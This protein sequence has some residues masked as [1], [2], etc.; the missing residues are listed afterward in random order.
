MGIEHC[1]SQKIKEPI[2][3]FI[4]AWINFIV[5]IQCKEKNKQDKFSIQI[6]LLQTFIK[7]NGWGMVCWLRVLQGLKQAGTSV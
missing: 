2:Q 5:K 1:C 6:Q 4:H 7:G 3:N